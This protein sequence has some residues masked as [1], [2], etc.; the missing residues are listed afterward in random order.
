MDGEIA[1][2]PANGTVDRDGRLLAADPRLAELNARAG[3]AIGD[4]LAVAPLGVIARL[5]QRLGI[6]VA[7]TV[8]V[9]DGSDEIE[10]WVR[11][12][13]I[14]TGVRLAVS[15]WRLRP[16]WTPRD[17]ARRDR[18][19]LARD[20]DWMWECDAALCIV[21]IDPR[22]STVGIDPR[23][24]LGQPLTALVTPQPREDGSMPLLG[25]LTAHR[26]FED[27]PVVLP[28]NRQHALI[29]AV[30]R[31]DAEGVFAGYSGATRMAAKPAP[32]ATDIV[33]H[34]PADEAFGGRLDRALRGPLGRI[35][36]NADS[37]HAQ[38][39]GPIRKDYADYAADIASAGRHLMGLV[40][41]L[42]DL[43]AVERAD[44]RPA[45]DPIDLADVAIRA[46]G[47]L[48]VRASERGV[49]ID[50]PRPDE[51]APATGEFRR[52]LQILVNLIGNAVRYSPDSGTVW[53][54]TTA[55]QGRALVI[56]ADQGKGI[57]PEDQARIFE[58]FE[59]V[60]PGEPGG[61]GLGL[62]IARRLARAMGGDLAVDSAPGQGARFV[63]SLPERRAATAGHD[64]AAEV[65]SSNSRS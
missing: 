38:S 23:G 1:M 6:V 43:Q 59:R 35:I 39:D 52:V 46:A 10:L 27:E 56:V 47:L 65:S 64:D 32:V 53:I 5:A 41:D 36:A 57:A 55:E 48:S 28:A 21:S 51:I 44:F 60:D 9:A 4:M 14:D 8:V 11:A 16:A 42:V 63:L 33:P 20:A 31:R 37:I 13:P 3:G 25:L 19:L 26:A 50:A 15:G 58:K 30:P 45:A 34:E 62:Y 54:R 2:P 17:G 12:E 61:S 29:S 40:D 49:A 22:A 7:R 18:D 24:A